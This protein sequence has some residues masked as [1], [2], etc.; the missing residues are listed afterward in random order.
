MSKVTRSGSFDLGFLARF[1]DELLTQLAEETRDHAKT[2]MGA[3]GPGPHS[4]PGDPPRRQTS[5]LYNNVTAVVGSHESATESTRPSGAEEVPEWLEYGTPGGK[6][7]PR[8]YMRPAYERTLAE[9]DR[10]VTDAK[11]RAVK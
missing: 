4:L 3:P 5:D 6:V 7:A 9:V 10:I 11:G 8:P 2:S 1:E